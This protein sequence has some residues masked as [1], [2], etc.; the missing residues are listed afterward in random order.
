MT[1]S[2]TDMQALAHDRSF[3]FETIVLLHCS[4]SSS[5]QWRSLLQALGNG[6][7]PLA[8]DLYGHGNCGWAGIDMENQSFRCRGTEQC[9]VRGIFYISGPG[10]GISLG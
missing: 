6:F 7:E 2:T 5:R 4:A 1:S 9:S 8:I 10:D 3:A